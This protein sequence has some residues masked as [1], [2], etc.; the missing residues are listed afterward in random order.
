[1]VLAVW[2]V[3]TGA[4]MSDVMTVV[5]GALAGSSIYFVTC[6]LMHDEGLADVIQIIRTRG[7]WGTPDNL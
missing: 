2:A 5:V 7:R 4:N 6:R 3:R 1:M